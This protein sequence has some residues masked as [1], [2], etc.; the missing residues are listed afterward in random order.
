MVMR[1]LFAHTFSFGK[2]RFL[3]VPQSTTKIEIT[4]NKDGNN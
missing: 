1:R 4:D 3:N 2:G